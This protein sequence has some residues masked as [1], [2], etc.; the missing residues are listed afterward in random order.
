MF[1]TPIKF[2]D[3]DGVK[4]LIT[5]ISA[6][7]SILDDAGKSLDSKIDIIKEQVVGLIK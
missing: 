7:K 5:R 3:A 4:T 1:E 2:L 6:M